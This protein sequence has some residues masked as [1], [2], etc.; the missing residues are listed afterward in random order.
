[1][2]VNHGSRKVRWIVYLN[3]PMG[4]FEVIRAPSIES[5]KRALVRY[6]EDT[7]FYH[8]LQASGQYGC[9]A[10]LYPFTQEDWDEALEYEEIGCP[11]DY[12]SKIIERGPRG[13]VKVTNA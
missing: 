8:D 6:C 10:S 12:P 2:T 11:F 5:A 13:G 7:G 4:G 1:M 9:S 3:H